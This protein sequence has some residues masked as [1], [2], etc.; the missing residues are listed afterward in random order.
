VPTAW[1]IKRH[2]QQL[3]DMLTLQTDIIIVI[4]ITI[5]STGDEFQMPGR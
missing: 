1:T 4:I 3:L 5:G 2:K